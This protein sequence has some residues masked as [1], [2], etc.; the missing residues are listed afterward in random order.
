MVVEV[1]PRDLSTGQF[2]EKRGSEPGI[3]LNATK[4]CGKCSRWLPTADFGPNRARG[5]GLQSQCN[6]CRKATNHVYYVTTPERNVERVASLIDARQEVRAF[7]TEY[8][9][10][11]PCVDCGST[12]AVTLEFD[13][14][15]GR[16]S[17]EIG[18]S[19]H[20]RLQRVQEEIEKCEV[21]CANCH[22]IQTEGRRKNSARRLIHDEGWD[23][24]V[25]TR[26]TEKRKAVLGSLRSGCVDCGNVDIRV[27]EYDHPPGT[28]LFALSKP[29]GR[30]LGEIIAEIAKCEVRCRNHH[31]T[32]T[33]DRRVGAS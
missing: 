32:V 17:F 19:G 30:S 7:V 26:P 13:H 14:V 18:N 9:L 24:W 31:R 8:F 22:A 10:S 25:A 1:Q 11:H 21:R 4:F 16:K 33:A 15:R 3:T 23:A 20:H 29:R 5:D 27:L 12:D 6:E 2:A 28:K